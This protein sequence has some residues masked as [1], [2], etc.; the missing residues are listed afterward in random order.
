ML[1]CALQGP[2]GPSRT[3]L[4]PEELEPA[5]GLVCFNPATT[6]A[7]VATE[8]DL[9]ALAGY[10]SKGATFHRTHFET[11]PASE[12]HRGVSRAQEALW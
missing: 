12:R 8:R 2:D 6:N 3:P 11:C 10:R 7:I 4:D 9:N 5:A 1:W